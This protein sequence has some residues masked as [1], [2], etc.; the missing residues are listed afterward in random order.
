M[1]PSNINKLLTKFGNPRA[2]KL[3]TVLKRKASRS[4]TTKIMAHIKT[5][6]TNK[7]MKIMITSTMIISYKVTSSRRR[8]RRK[9]IRMEIKIKMI[10]RSNRSHNSRRRRR[11]RLTVKR[12]RMKR[13]GRSCLRRCRVLQGTSNKLRGRL[14][15]T[16]IQP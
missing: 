10:I 4:K 6:K 8:R 12:I 2:N 14:R 13:T 3:K 9:I 11:N 16:R 5:I 15:L 1:K 7:I